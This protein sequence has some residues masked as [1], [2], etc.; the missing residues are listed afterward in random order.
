MIRIGGN[1]RGNFREGHDRF[2]F[3]KVKFKQFND[4]RNKIKMYRLS[5]C[6][7]LSTR[8]QVYLT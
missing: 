4:S 1:S 2:H 8:F 5:L 6:N 3:S 7:I